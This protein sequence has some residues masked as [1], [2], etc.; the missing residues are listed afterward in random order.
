MKPRKRLIMIYKRQ[1][2]LHCFHKNP[3]EDYK[4]I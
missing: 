2:M 1:I 4:E 3:I